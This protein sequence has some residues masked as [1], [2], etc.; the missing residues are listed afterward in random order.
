MRSIVYLAGDRWDRVAGTDK[1]LAL[2]LAEHALVLWMDP[3]LSALDVARSR[4]GIHDR[5]ATEEV[6]PG[7]LR[8]RTVTPP[9]ASRPGF[10][11]MATS[12]IDRGAARAVARSGSDVAA[13]ILA[14]PRQTFPASLPGV[15]VLYVTDDWVA[16]SELM[17]LQRE[18]VARTLAANIATADVVC[19][20]TPYLAQTIESGSGRKVRVLANGCTVPD[21]PTVASGRLRTAVIVGQLNERLDFDCLEA[22]ADAGVPILAVGP[23]TERDSETR[24]RL[25]VLFRRPEVTWVG[26][27]PHSELPGL[28]ATARVGLT[29]YLDNEFN[30]SSFP[31]KTLEYL[32]N[33]LPV[34]AT[35]LPAV[36]WLDTDLINVAS[37]PAAFARAAGLFVAADHEGAIE[38]RAFAQVHSWSA[39]A[40][41]LEAWVREVAP[42]TG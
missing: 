11:R 24:A 41:Q 23:R 31:L 35:D 15:R 30:R 20:V 4:D 32:A 28:L 10:R 5:T 6:A 26:E 33:G 13:V 1:R 40:T 39:R 34:V 36:R 2:A 14:S 17:G 9:F 37:E 42:R 38:R 18:W 25:D 16:G 29:P 3:P 27:V 8:V 12:A 19:A 22:V 7:V 21:T